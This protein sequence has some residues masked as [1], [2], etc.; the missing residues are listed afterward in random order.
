MLAHYGT[1]SGAA[2]GS[3]AASG[4]PMAAEAAAAPP[5]AL[6]QRYFETL[7]QRSIK[8]LGTF[9]RQPIARGRMHYLDFIPATLESIQRC[10]E[11]L[12]QYAALRDIFPLRFDPSAARERA[13]ELNE[14]LS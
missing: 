4:S 12:P 7:L 6:R 5:A 13:R 10:L 8:I 3:V 1:L 14:A 9:S 11:E 2:A